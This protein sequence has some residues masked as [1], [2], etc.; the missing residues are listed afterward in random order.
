MFGC[1]A[2]NSVWKERERKE[3]RKKLRMEDDVEKGIMQL[4]KHVKQELAAWRLP[5]KAVSRRISRRETREIAAKEERE[6][7][8]EYIF[9]SFVLLQS[10]F[11]RKIINSPSK[12][13]FFL[14]LF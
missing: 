11:G 3:K 9:I 14:R 4:A 8:P 2:I 5:K 7:K 10:L 13:A 6:T 12:H 1:F